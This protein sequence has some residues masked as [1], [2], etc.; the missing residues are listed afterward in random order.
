MN[1]IETKAARRSPFLIR[2]AV[3]ALGLAAVAAAA[4]WQTPAR[5]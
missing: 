2:G 1:G 5:S 3:A 4:L